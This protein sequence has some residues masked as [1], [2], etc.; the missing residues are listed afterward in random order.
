MVRTVASD[1]TRFFLGLPGRND[2]TGFGV[3]L[4]YELD[5]QANTPY[6][7]ALI[8]RVR[9]RLARRSNLRFST[10]ESM[11]SVLFFTWN[12]GWSPATLDDYPRALAS[13]AAADVQGALARCRSNA[14]ITVLDREVANPVGR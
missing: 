2:K 12:L 5:P 8:E 1:G 4:Q 6:D 9:W 14:V 3:Y 13:I 11:A 7:A 10:N